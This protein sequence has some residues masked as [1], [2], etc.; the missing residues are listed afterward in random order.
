MNSTTRSLLF[1]LII[2]AVA[3]GVYQFAQAKRSASLP[4]TTQ[5]DLAGEWWV[6]DQ[7]DLKCAIFRQGDVLLIV[8]GR[9]DLATAKIEAEARVVILKG[10]GWALGAAAE[11]RDGGKTLAWSGGAAWRRR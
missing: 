10:E 11:I 7:P 9:G 3:V 2:V 1:W 4:T 8:N 6:S 5:A